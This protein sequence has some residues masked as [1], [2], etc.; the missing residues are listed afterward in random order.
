MKFIFYLFFIASNLNAQEVYIRIIDKEKE[1]SEISYS[2]PTLKN[3]LNFNSVVERKKFDKSGKLSFKLFVDEI[4]S[5]E[6]AGASMLV[7][8]GDSIIIESSLTP[9][10]TRNVQTLNILAKNKGNLLW[11]SQAEKLSILKIDETGYNTF[12][13]HKMECKK[14]YN[15]MI[16]SLN[17]FALRYAISS[18]AL[19]VFQQELKYF[20][21]QNL[22]A[23]VSTKRQTENEINQIRSE[24]I[25]YLVSE[26][27]LYLSKVYRNCLMIYFD[28]LSM[29]F[30][31]QVNYLNPE[32]FQSQIV[33]AANLGNLRIRDYLFA[34]IYFYYHFMN[35]QLNDNVMPLK[36]YCND[37]IL[38]IQDPLIINEVLNLSQFDQKNEYSK[39]KK[40]IKNIKL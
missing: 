12:F 22:S 30:G 5:I 4:A 10:N 37:M 11:R 19:N 39:N 3:L 25:P 26:K 29:P 14:V 21:L 33:K 9:K 24:F 7:E 28:D 20:Y 40:I 2:E 36:S 18:S 8:N 35:F 6:L 38:K 16:D 1:Q 32:I 31:N 13:E 23:W 27:L 17:S 34:R 15:L